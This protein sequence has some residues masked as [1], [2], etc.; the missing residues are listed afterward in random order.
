MST[1][2]KQENNSTREQ[3]EQ[4]RLDG[5]TGIDGTTRQLLEVTPPELLGHLHREEQRAHAQRR[6]PCHAYSEL[7][8]KGCHQSLLPSYR[9]PNAVGSIRPLDPYG[10]V[11]TSAG[12]FLLQMVANAEIES[13]AL[14]A[15]W[16]CTGFLAQV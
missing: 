5:G 10:M 12:Q 2:H 3:Q 11:D 6:A 14:I 4:S 16:G 8:L 9:L 15:T 7:S 13:S 1:V